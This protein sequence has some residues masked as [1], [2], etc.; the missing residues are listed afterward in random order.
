MRI[1]LLAPLHREKEY[2]NQRN[3][4]NFFLLGQAHTAWIDALKQLG[5]KVFVFRFTDSV[6][7]PNL[8]KVKFFGFFQKIMPRLNGKY[9]KFF[10]IFYFLSIDNILKNFKL[11]SLVRIKAPEIIFISGE[12]SSIFPTT[13]R[14]I[15]NKYKCKVVLISGIN[16][17]IAATKV[18]KIIVKSKIADLVVE[19]DESYARSWK[20]LGA[21][22]VIVLP[23]SSLDPKLHRVIKLTKQ[24]ME[25][26]GCDV[27][28]VGTLN[29]YRQDVL[30]NLTN[31]NLK[32]WGDI[33]PGQKIKKE[34]A[35][36]YNG[37][38]YGLKMV[39]IFNAAK[40]IINF[41]P[42]DMGEGGNMRTFE[43]PG[44][45]AFQL[46]D[47]VDKKWF[48]EDKEIVLF[49]NGK[50]LKEKIVYYLKDE[51]EREDIAKRGFVKAHK[52]HTYK[53][54]FN[55]LFKIIC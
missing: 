51:K 19:N 34:L 4:G 18:E 36:L 37:A 38:A 42:Q 46:A 41:Q 40:I 35:L 39:K 1:L 49:K 3:N 54:H 31:F 12:I 52:E 47:R 5:H 22:R 7:I 11:L 24:E 45:N 30:S 9:R 32:I 53:S 21:E 29:R 25:T 23:I 14:V 44:C 26:Y 20:K 15:K 28:F 17:L 33:P 48:R 6:I 55:K 16:P 43:I 8:L 50:D 2:F 10:D 13:I 27:C